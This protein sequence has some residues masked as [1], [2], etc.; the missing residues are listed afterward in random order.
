MNLLDQNL[1]VP[2]QP[3]SWPAPFAISGPSP[4]D[5]EVAIRCGDSC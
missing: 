4:S 2:E 3:F 5:A 1:A